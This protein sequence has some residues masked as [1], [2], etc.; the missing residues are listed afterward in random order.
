MAMMSLV[1]R[2]TFPG[3]PAVQNS[4]YLKVSPLLTN[5]KRQELEIMASG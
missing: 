4:K 3:V 2:E 1:D 5:R